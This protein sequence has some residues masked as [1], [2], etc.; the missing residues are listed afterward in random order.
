MKLKALKPRLHNI[1]FHTHTVSGIVIS[2]ALY[3][4]FYAGA[5][6][7]FMDELYQ[8]ENPNAR[9]VA[10]NPDDV[11]YDSLL[12]LVEDTYPNFDK[13]QQFGMVPPK[14]TN[15]LVTFYGSLKVDDNTIERFNA[16]INPITYKIDSGK[17]PITHM[18]RTIYELHYFNQIPMIGIYLS[19]LVAFFFLFAIFTGLLTHW[20]NIVNKF[21]AFT[22]KG[23]WK[24]IWTNGH[25]SLGVI[26]LPFQLIY[27]I[28][29]A[30]LGLSILLLAPTAFLV[31]DGDTNEV[32]KVVRP[33]AAIKY[34]ENAKVADKAFTF[35]SAYES[36][37][38]EIEDLDVVYLYTRNYG[39]V[40]G[41]IAAN[42]ADNKGIGSDGSFI[43]SVNDGELIKAT[44]PVTRSYTTGALAVLIKLHYATYGGIFLK[45][46][47]F[48]L[49][50]FTC[51][52]ILSGVLIWRTARDNNKYTVKQK[53][54]HHR[55]TKF[56]LAVTLS[57]FP[58]IGIIF[59]AN[60]LVPL[61]TVNRILYVNSAFFIGWLVLILI[62]L[63]WNNYRKLNRNYIMIG[64]VFGI[65]IPIVN[66]IITGDWLWKTL[67]NKQYYVFSVDVTWLIIGV[68][69][70]LICKY[71]LTNKGL[72][73]T[74]SSELNA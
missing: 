42:V 20:K 8:W 17:E 5:V 15:P 7:L 23:K 27:A 32:I 9:E 61:E 53:R 19:G 37:Q 13:T 40:D 48:I 57:M 18:A 3:I 58:S 38:N 44:R 25:V 10:I 71:Y 60:K 16:Y 63:F 30:L 45:I 21:Y 67:V 52:I 33:D 62:G 2:F 36:V 22:T 11:D 69:G 24:Q 28:T 70:I 29:G 66:G 73:N 51:Y 68:S 74:L 35:N 12:K 55:V 6:A 4:M 14:E 72:T 46:I 47:Y 1:M 41:T 31:F 49:A 50:M 65:L 26:T 34:D 59:L 56:Y 39:K 43:Y 64:S 54:F